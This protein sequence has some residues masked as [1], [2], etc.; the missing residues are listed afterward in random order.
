MN[1]TFTTATDDKLI[2]LIQSAV[3]RL[4]IVAPG[5]TTPVAEALGHCIGTLSAQSLTVILDTDPEVYRM[6]YGDMQ[7][8]ENIRRASSQ[9][10]FEL[11]EQ[12][13]VRIGVIVSDHRAMVYS[14]V[15]RN[16]EAGSTSV[17]KPNALVIEGEAADTLA[18]ATA[19]AGAQTEV[20]QTA[21]T[22]ERVDQMV[23]NLNA[24]PPQPFDLSRKLRVFRSE[25]Q[26]VELK[27]T[28]ATFRS[29]KIQLPAQFQKLKDM[30]LRSRISSTLKMPID[31]ETEL[32]ISIGFGAGRE[33]LMVNEKYIVR[34]RQQL[35]RVF[36]HDWKA[37]GK[38]IL[39]KDK[40]QAGKQLNRLIGIIKA[41]HCVLQGKID[42]SRKTFR[43]QFVT[44]FVDLWKEQPPAHL[45]MRDDMDEQSYR[46]DL[47]READQLFD[48]AVAFGDPHHTVVYKDVA[49]EDLADPALMEE[50]KQLMRRARVGEKTLTKL[51]E[52]VDAAAA[53]DS[54]QN[55]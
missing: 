29:R 5:L 27:M 43:E 54:T 38:V 34:E 50:L 13:G 42:E 32:E 51:F 41:Y 16:V 2:E 23:A 26:F 21:L 47:E 4:I 37:R 48:K 55:A 40:E 20:G 14:P 1:R 24:D 52:V 19:L 11:R 39:R 22:S 6:G 15:P 7:A 44:E 53:K 36:F 8:L 35:E 49:I 3:H 28:N 31:L 45:R 9:E 12:P 25:V 18:L 30:D 10:L 33:T 17:E 46:T